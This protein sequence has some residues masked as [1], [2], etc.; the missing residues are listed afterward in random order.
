[1]IRPGLVGL[2]LAAVTAAGAGGY[3]LGR[4]DIAPLETIR[5]A[6]G[7]AS[8]GEASAT[9]SSDPAAYYRH[10]DGKPF[11][12]LAPR[13][14]DEGRDYLAVGVDEDVRFDKTAPGVKAA[15]ETGKVLYYRNPMGL[16][17]TSPVPKKDS[18]G[19]DYIP[20]YE[21]EDGGDGSTVVVAPGR[22]QR[23]GVRSE[24]VS[25]HVIAAPVRVPGAVQLD[26]RGVSIVATRTD[27]FVQEVSNV[28]TGEFVRRGTPLMRIYSPEIAA[29]G[30]QYLSDVNANRRSP[31]SRQRLEN[32]AI[33]DEAIAAIERTREVP[34][35]IEWNSP[36]DGVVLERN[37][38]PGMKAEP[39][40][41]LFRIADISTL[42]VVADVPEYQMSSVRVG[43]VATIRVRGLPGKIFIGPVTL[44]YPEVDK[45]T[46]TTKVRIEIPNPDGILRPDMYA[47]VE[48]ATGDEKPVVAVPDE[49]IID[50]GTKRIVIIDEGEG[51][52]K[53]RDVET[54]ARGGGLTEVR[55]GVAAGDRVVVAANFLIDAESNLQAAFRGLTAAEGAQ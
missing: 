2:A 44:V 50:T 41:V 9:T 30:A 12:S 26:E 23:T 55:S 27:A 37:A 5:L 14:T 38:V 1:M 53:P 25:E 34:V 48:I 42:W 52:F 21:G 33:P 46:R 18:M 8:A 16:P 39:G 22:L 31:G 49:A 10:P 40:S 6:P 45:A 7:S 15:E 4:S 3:W 19:M 29:A 17:D 20:V 13:K 36:R 35:L 28:T 32:L 11:Y 47:E 54:G 24:L 43:S 51:R